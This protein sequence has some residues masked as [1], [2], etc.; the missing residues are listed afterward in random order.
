MNNGPGFPTT[1]GVLGC[2]ISVLKQKVPGKRG[3]IGHPTRDPSRPNSSI[4]LSGLLA[5]V[6]L[7]CLSSRNPSWPPEPLLD[8]LAEYTPFDPQCRHFRGFLPLPFA[9]MILQS[10]LRDLCSFPGLATT[11]HSRNHSRGEPDSITIS[12]KY[13][14]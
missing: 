3:H 12:C 14:K 10:L 11:S 8:L 2:G 13:P 9:P 7:T 5:V 4:C 6:Y 1:E